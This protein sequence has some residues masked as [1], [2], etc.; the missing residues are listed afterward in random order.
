M[1]YGNL[2]TDI[3]PA[4]VTEHTLWARPYS[5]PTPRLLWIMALECESNNARLAAELQQRLGGEYAV[6]LA[7]SAQILGSDVAGDAYWSQIATTRETAVQEDLAAKVA[8]AWDVL[9]L[10]TV[11]WGTLP[12]T[13]CALIAAR[14]RDGAG[15]V[16][17]S[18]QPEPFPPDFAELLVAP[19]ETPMALRAAFPAEWLATFAALAPL[20]ITYTCGAGRIAELRQHEKWPEDSAA[21]GPVGRW[22]DPVVVNF[23]YYLSL[24][25]QAVL[26]AGRQEP[27]V[28]IVGLT[29]IATSWSPYAGTL[30]LQI[31]SAAPDAR[32]LTVEIVFR[33][34]RNRRQTGPRQP[35][36]IT[37]GLCQQSVLLGDLRPGRQFID[38]WL[39]D[40]NDRV[41]CWASTYLEVAQELTIT[42]VRLDRE[43]FERDEIISGTADF[44]QP[45]PTG[46]TLTV[47][48]FDN[49]GRLLEQ[50]SPPILPAAFIAFAIPAAQVT[51]PVAYLLC[52]LTAGN[53][54][55]GCVEQEVLVAQRPPADDFTLAV[56]LI[57]EGG[58]SHLACQMLRRRELSKFGVRYAYLWAAPP[59]A[60]GAARENQTGIPGAL[61]LGTLVKPDTVCRYP[62][63]QPCLSD[64]ERLKEMERT[65]RAF[66]A[67]F[68]P[69]GPPFISLGG[70]RFVGQ[71]PHGAPDLCWSAS[72]LAVFREFVQE[73]YG[74]LEALNRQYGT[75]CTAWEQVQPGRWADCEAS[76]NY[77]P[78]VDH[79]LAMDRVATRFFT[80]AA[81][82]VQDTDPRVRVGWDSPVGLEWA[83]PTMRSSF[84][85]QLNYDYPALLH[86]FTG[87]VP[88]DS[89]VERELI[90]SLTP[91]GYYFSEWWGGYLADRYEWWQRCFPW[92]LISNG[93]NSSW[94]FHDQGPENALA[95]DLRPTPWF[96]WANEELREIRAGVGKLLLNAEVERD[97]IAVLW[98]QSGYWAATIGLGAAGRP[99]RP[100]GRMLSLLQDL[101]LSYR[102][103]TGEQ[104]ITG[105]LQADGCRLLVL[106]WAQALSPEEAAA[107]RAFVQAG[108][109]VL[110]DVRPGVLDPHCAVLPFGQLDDVFG[111]A[112]HPLDPASEEERGDDPLPRYERGIPPD[113]G[114]IFVNRFGQG[115]VLLLNC[116]LDGYGG[117]EGGG[118]PPPGFRVEPESEPFRA[119]LRET[120]ATHGLTAPVRLALDGMPQAGV[121]I[122]RYRLGDAWYL[123][124]L[125][126][127]EVL[128]PAQAATVYLPKSGHLYDVRRGRYLGET[129]RFNAVIER[130]IAQLYALL[131]Y[132]V[133]KL[134]LNAP[135]VVR[136]NDVLVCRICIHTTSALPTTHV[137]H[138][139]LLDPDA[140]SVP[141]GYLNVLAE[142]GCCDISLPLALNETPGEWT[143][144]ARDIAT[145]VRTEQIVM[146]NR[147]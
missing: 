12:A 67:D 139:E 104:L 65:V 119:R 86:V 57:W 46:S 103:I 41:V 69:F 130:G 19:V 85:F 71:T 21:T 87:L 107:I 95:L 129:D 14:I 6:S 116:L 99:N 62:V 38:V 70:E 4:V 118:C 7:Y 15:L 126:D 22:A 39:R 98:T 79:M 144:R 60:A 132:R 31:A 58:I 20:I 63:R 34:T 121:E 113:T 112:P 72:C 110:A 5:R 13:V 3:T 50:H 26:W 9:L 90:R 37:P 49:Y 25:C 27:D 68:R 146:I 23:E 115:A 93:A 32:A 59:A 133:E 47:S 128:R 74:T 143:L 10:D 81:R 36:T 136:A 83:A 114:P 105:A 45:P 111:L 117:S 51:T 73:Q 91:D 142:Q 124:L 92:R 138:L 140:Q 80:R 66:T 102:Y 106:P 43:R 84:V 127:K 135:R 28:T 18:P 94:Y 24:L 16:L 89:Q 52:E 145:G 53:K 97:G 78:W 40:T 54:L 125:P 137:F 55:L 8:S 42:S 141:W 134:E 35:L 56:S 61:N 101:G 77:A 1:D 88:Y 11:A 30:S 48:L 33:D 131:P 100:H 109:I 120:L 108:G 17:T 82:A 64:P 2:Y 76:G 96:L 122:T 123:A 44:A 29:A 75:T 147:R